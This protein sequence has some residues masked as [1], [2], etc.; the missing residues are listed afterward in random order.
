MNFNLELFVSYVSIMLI[1]T[2]FTMSIILLVQFI[3]FYII[4]SRPSNK[5]LYDNGGRLAL[6]LLLFSI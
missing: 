6:V 3:F 4:D 1:T 2:L 5:Y